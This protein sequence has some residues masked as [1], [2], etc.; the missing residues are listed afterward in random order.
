MLRDEF[1]NFFLSVS[2]F[3]T[4]SRISVSRSRASRREW[5][6]DLTI[7]CFETRARFFLIS[8]VL[9]GENGS[10][11]FQSHASRR[12]REFFLSVSFFETR[13]SVLTL[14][15]WDE[16]ENNVEGWLPLFLAQSIINKLAK[17]RKMRKPPGTL[18][19][20]KFWPDKIWVKNVWTQILA[21]LHSCILSY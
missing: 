10:F 17:A 6:F 19:L 15:L 5:E 12:E 11:Y 16:N 13:I 7:L 8:L 18:G 9:W 20:K 3:E 21:Y 14:V 2:C 4:R 1:E